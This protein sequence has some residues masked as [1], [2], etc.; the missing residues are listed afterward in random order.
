MGAHLIE[1]KGKSDLVRKKAIEHLKAA[2][3]QQNNHSAQSL[4][5]LGLGQAA[6]ITHKYKTALKRLNEVT[7]DNQLAHLQAQGLKGQLYASG[8]LGSP[9]KTKANLHLAPIANRELPQPDPTRKHLP[10]LQAWQKETDT[11]LIARR[12]LMLLYPSLIEPSEYEGEDPP[13]LETVQ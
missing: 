4:A 2:A 10:P 3:K 11:I 1:T 8:R 6:I 5:K 13:A 7:E 9:N 12:K